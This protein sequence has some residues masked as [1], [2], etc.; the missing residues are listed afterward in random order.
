MILLDTY[1]ILLLLLLL[2]ICRHWLSYEKYTLTDKS[3]F[4]KAL[5]LIIHKKQKNYIT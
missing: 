2:L 3:I 4:W 5:L 1:V